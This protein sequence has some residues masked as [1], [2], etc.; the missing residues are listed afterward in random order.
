MLLVGVSA[1]PAN[2]AMQQLRAQAAQYEQQADWDRA[3]EC[4]EALLRFDR[5]LGDVKTRHQ[6]CLRRYW[7][8]RR[9]LDESYRKEVLGLEYGQ[10]LQLYRAFLNTLQENALDGKRTTIGRMFRKGLEELQW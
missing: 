9:H 3:C 6:H 1:A 2:T 7:Q 10:A 5:T 4:Y 8:A